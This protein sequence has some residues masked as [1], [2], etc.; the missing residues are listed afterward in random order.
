MHHIDPAA[1]ASNLPVV[2]R[3]KV[4]RPEPVAA[5]KL[6]EGQSERL[7]RSRQAKGWSLRDLAAASG[8][9]VRTILAIESGTAK[10]ATGCNTMARL[11]DALHVPRGWLAFGG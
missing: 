9:S 2:P 3:P 6:A 8:V 10:G 4:E 7:L 11:A 5:P 1:D